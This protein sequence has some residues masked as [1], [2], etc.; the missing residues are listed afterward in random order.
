M[1]LSGS[2]FVTFGCLLG[3]IWV[4]IGSLWVPFGYLRVPFWTALGSLWRSLAPPGQYLCDFGIILGPFDCRKGP[5]SDEERC[6]DFFVFFFTNS[7]I[8]YVSVDEKRTITGDR[9]HPIHPI[10]SNAV[11]KDIVPVT[12]YPMTGR[13][14][15]IQFASMLTTSSRTLCST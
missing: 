8:Y 7:L 2:M 6:E 5:K 3:N 9:K 15:P 14:H 11:I 10:Q 1:A 12:G 13:T 4:S